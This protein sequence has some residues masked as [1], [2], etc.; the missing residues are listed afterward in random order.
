MVTSNRGKTKRGKTAV[1]MVLSTVSIVGLGCR[2]R[3]PVTADSPATSTPAISAP[4]PAAGVERTSPV[5]PFAADLDTLNAHLRREGL[6]AP[7]YFDYDSAELSAAT[8]N[9]LLADARFLGEHPELVIGIDGHADE[10]GT[11]DYNLALGDRRA[12]SVAD[13][14]RTYGVGGERLRTTT[15]GEERPACTTAAAESCW[16]LNRRAEFTVVGRRQVG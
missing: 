9:R 11:N 8:R 5:D 13:V 6:L 2:Q 3:P 16:R 15:Y 1:L 4:A 14:L 7:I 10:R 12:G